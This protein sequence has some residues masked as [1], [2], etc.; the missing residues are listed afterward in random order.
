MKFFYPTIFFLLSCMLGGAQSD[1]SISTL[2]PDMKFNRGT[3]TFNGVTA[4]VLVATQQ[5]DLE[6]QIYQQIGQRRTVF[7]E[8]ASGS[9]IY[10]ILNI[11]SAMCPTCPHPD[12]TTES[13]VLRDAWS[14]QSFAIDGSSQFAVGTP[15]AALAEMQKGQ[16]QLPKALS[17]LK[18][19]ASNIQSIEF[20][21]N[22]TTNKITLASLPIG[23]S[24]AANGIDEKL[25]QAGYQASDGQVITGLDQ[26]Q[27]GKSH[28][29]SKSYMAQKRFLTVI[30]TEESK[31]RQQMRLIETITQ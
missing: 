8:Y 14:I 19:K 5:G 2:L 29:F 15:L 27:V 23:Q 28:E 12:E 24:E 10:L 1:R 11:R 18:K 17:S 4:P 13:E 31:H 30:L 26:N 16:G 21:F 6:A 25:R 3:M 20:S 22:G 9:P 7:K